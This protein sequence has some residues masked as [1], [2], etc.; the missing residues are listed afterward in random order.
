MGCG[1]Q[2]LLGKRGNHCDSRKHCIQ[3][4]PTIWRF[5]KS[6]IYGLILGFFLLDFGF[7]YLALCLF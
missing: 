2:Q 7:V 5:K 4:N 1:I 6:K 3:Q